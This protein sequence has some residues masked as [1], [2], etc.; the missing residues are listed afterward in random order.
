MESFKDLNID[1]WIRIPGKALLS[2]GYAITYPDQIGVSLALN[3]YYF[4]HVKKVQKTDDKCVKVSVKNP[5]FPCSDF[6]CRVTKETTMCPS[7]FIKACVSLVAQYFK[8]ISEQSFFCFDYE[9]TLLQSGDFYVQNETAKF[10]VPSES[11]LKAYTLFEYPHPLV[12][13]QKNGFGSSACLIV[14]LVSGLLYSLDKSLLKEKELVYI[15]SLMANFEAQ[16]KIGSGFDI[17][18]LFY[19]FN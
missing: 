6:L 18:K 3:V 1:S 9:I 13:T 12:E 19:T 7:R 4:V 8:S 16:Q 5:Q 10:E 2:G 15:L 17:G 11:G 14:G